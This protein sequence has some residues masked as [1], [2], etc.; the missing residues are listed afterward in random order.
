[1]ARP[2]VKNLKVKCANCDFESANKAE[3]A[4]HFGECKP[5]RKAQDRKIEAIDVLAIKPDPEQPRKEFAEDAIMELAQSIQRNGLLQPI[6]VR[7]NCD[8]YIIIAG[9]RRFRAVSTLEWETIDCIVY[10]GSEKEA[11]ELQFVEN[12]NRED[13]NPIEIAEGHQKFLDEGYELD[14]ISKIVGEPKNIISWL[15]NV[16]KAKPEVQAMVKKDQISLVVAIALGKLSHNGQ[17]RALN[18]M[19]S[20]KMNVAEC[21]KLCERIYAEENAID[22]FPEA[23]LS[24]EEIKARE[25]VES[26]IDKA[27]KALSEVADTENENPG[28]TAM[29]IAERLDITKE[30]LD[31]MSQ[32]VLKIRRGLEAKRVGAV[33]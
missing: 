2:E 32:A 22:M 23:K 1:M 9:E 21:Q 33:C 15:R 18:T 24:S 28:I 31:M 8:G 11:K 10:N 30:K 27:C 19:V 6:S 29:A 26:A 16:L 14:E 4:K 3:L 20:N 25:K 7:R 13:L 17:T 5:K 12:I